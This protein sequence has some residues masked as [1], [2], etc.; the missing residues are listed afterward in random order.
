MRGVF[1][2]SLAASLLIILS[3]LSRL[4]GAAAATTDATDTKAM[5]ALR[6]AWYGDNK[7]TLSTWNDDDDPCDNWVGVTCSSARR[8]T[9]LSYS[10]LVGTLPSEIGLLAALTSLSLKSIKLS[11]TLPSTLGSLVL[12]R[13][14][15]IAA[16]RV[17]G[18][19]PSSLGQLTLLTSLSLECNSLSGALPS[20]LTSLT[21]LTSLALANNS[22]LCGSD[23][24][25]AKFSFA[26]TTGEIPVSRLGCQL[27]VGAVA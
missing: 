9:A 8:V 6:K 25:L 23:T 4:E 2:P 20:A 17:S 18:E 14:I 7:A 10:S 13:S 19:L 21:Q 22:G 15:S 27:S 24:V 1:F 3:L 26:T 12:A 11:G 16:S 5:A